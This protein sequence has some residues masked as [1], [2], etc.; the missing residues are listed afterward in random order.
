MDQMIFFAY[1]GSINADW[2]S[3][4][5][6]RMAGNTTGRKIRLLH[7]P[8]NITPL[9]KI[10]AKLETIENECRYHGVDFA[11]DIIRLDKN[12]YNTLV[13][14]IPAGNENYCICGMRTA[15]MGKGFLADTISEQLLRSRKFNVLAIRVVNPGLLGCPGNILFP[16]S[17]HP[18]AFQAAMPF[19]VMLAPY[20]HRLQILRIMSV[21]SLWFP[22][23]SA[24]AAR[25]QLDRGGDYVKMVVEEIRKTTVAGDLHLDRNVVLSDDWAKEIIIQ[26]GKLR[27]QMILLGASNRSL[28]SRFYYGNKI[29]QILRKSPCNIGIYRKI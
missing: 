28:P 12:V 29:E 10:Q 2:V 23:M 26:A 3:R 27:T 13:K 19:F 24:A 20:I 15:S 17:G 14:T 7:I 22:Y 25:K 8:D 4:Y 11:G 16:L 18:Q 21:N 5:A 9:Q 6:I 1:D